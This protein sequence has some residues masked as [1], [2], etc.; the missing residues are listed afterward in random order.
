M[1]MIPAMPAAALQH[2]TAIWKPGLNFKVPMIE[3]GC[4]SGDF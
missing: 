2:L 1:A 4:E 3:F